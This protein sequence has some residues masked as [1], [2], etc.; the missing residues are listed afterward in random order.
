MKYGGIMTVEERLRA[1]ELRV[2]S[3]F[4]GGA[5][6]LACVLGFLAFEKW[7]DIPKKIEAAFDTQIGKEKREKI[8]SAYKKA[9]NIESSLSILP[10]GSIIPWHK[11]LSKTSDLMAEWK[12]CDGSVVNDKDSRYVNLRVPDLNKTR[13]FLRG[14]QIS[15][16]EQ[17]QDWMPLE[18][19]SSIEGPSRYTHGPVTVS[20][21]SKSAKIFAGKW[22]QKA[23]ELTFTV[24]D[25]EVRPLNMSVVW[26]I[27]I[28]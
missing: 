28:K 17:D 11:S 3:V 2:T 9:I 12:E 24:K 21:R 18:I 22:E 13:R 20:S 14:G 4:A 1:L 15:G 23:N 7:Y 5:V 27:K 25:G 19:K 8:D 6:L 26:I 16:I 10:V